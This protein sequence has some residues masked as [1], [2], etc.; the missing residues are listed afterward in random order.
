MTYPNDDNYRT[1]SNKESWD[2]C[3]TTRQDALL[4][5]KSLMRS[6]YGIMKRSVYGKVK[7]GKTGGNF[8]VKAVESEGYKNWV[9]TG[10]G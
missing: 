2:A 3:W 9:R 4:H 6:E 7:I 5:K 10:R 1:P 8:C